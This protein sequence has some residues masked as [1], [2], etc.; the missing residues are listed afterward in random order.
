ML[1]AIL[2]L[3]MPLA[4]SAPLIAAWML[5]VSQPP[6]PPTRT[7]TSAAASPAARTPAIIVKAHTDVRIAT[8]PRLWRG[9][10]GHRAKPVRGLQSDTTLSGSRN[11]HEKKPT[12]SGD[13]PIGVAA[14]AS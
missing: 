6:P 2:I 14:K 11:R 10:E 12:R 4:G 8:L 3:V 1:R 5:V 9:P 13:L 7:S